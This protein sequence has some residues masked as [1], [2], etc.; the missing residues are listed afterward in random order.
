[1]PTYI[2]SSAASINFATATLMICMRARKKI[3]PTRPMNEAAMPATSA[4][5]LF[6]DMGNTGQ[7]PFPGF[8]IRIQR[9]TVRQYRS[10]SSP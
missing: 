2:A 5:V 4:S 8:G 9:G 1:M 6:L 7:A 3:V 10:H